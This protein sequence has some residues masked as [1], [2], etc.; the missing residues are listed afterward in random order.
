VNRYNYLNENGEHVH[1]LDEKP[2][3]GT[4]SVGD[5]LMKHGLTYWAAGLA[6]EKFGWKKKKNEDDKVRPRD[7]RVISAEMGRAKL[8]KL[9]P[10]E[11]LDLLDEAYSAH[12]KELDTSADKGKELHAEIEKYIKY[13]MSDSEVKVFESTDERIVPFIEWANE[14]V[15]R[16]LLSE[17]NVYSERMHTGGVCDCMVE[18]ND[19]TVGIIDFKSAKKTYTSHFLQCAG[20]SIQLKENGAFDK[21]GNQTMVTPAKIDWFAVVPFGKKKFV[22][23]IKRNVDELEEGFKSMLSLY[24]LINK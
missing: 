14:N 19:G 8:N 15:K 17:G 21:D 18:L 16:F 13:K 24:K 9:S 12:A 22:V 2:L 3:I 5:V 6:L 11:Y 7:E 4:S 10:D 20:Y 23:D 1:L